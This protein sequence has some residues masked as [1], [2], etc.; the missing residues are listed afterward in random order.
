MPSKRLYTSHDLQPIFNSY[1]NN[2]HE[3]LLSEASQEQYHNKGNDPATV[4]WLPPQVDQ[5]TLRNEQLWSMRRAYRTSHVIDGRLRVVNATVSLSTGTKSA[6]SSRENAHV[7]N[8]CFPLVSF[9]IPP[10]QHDATL[11]ILEGSFRGTSANLSPLSQSNK[12]L[13]SAPVLPET[14]PP[15]LEGWG[16]LIDS[17]RDKPWSSE[18]SFDLIEPYSLKPQNYGNTRRR[19][20]EHHEQNLQPAEDEAKQTSVRGPARDVPYSTLHHHGP[21]NLALLI[22][23][24]YI[25]QHGTK[26]Q[27]AMLDAWQA[28]EN[29][30]ERSDQAVVSQQ[31]S[32][33]PQVIAASTILSALIDEKSQDILPVYSQFTKM[34]TW[35]YQEVEGAYNKVMLEPCTSPSPPAR[36]SG[37]LHW[38]YGIAKYY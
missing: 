7:D 22:Q 10:Y 4:A 13:P 33:V 16:P 12:G 28:A 30:Q 35:E 17:I 11:K 2:L 36:H 6:Q 21:A 19:S 18:C 8:G 34:R 23:R 20:L 1:G 25:L 31:D 14:E 26:A 32:T 37:G 29:G 15:D 9:R 27:L 5:Q 24:T 3:H 38:F